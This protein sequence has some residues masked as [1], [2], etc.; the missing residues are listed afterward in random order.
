MKSVAFGAAAVII[1]IAT[2]FLG[3]SMFFSDLGPSESMVFRFSTLVLLYAVGGG[4]IGAL[5]PRAWYVAILAAWG[6]VLLTLP[7]LLGPRVGTPSSPADQMQ[8]GLL[9]VV[10]VPLAAL[11]FAFLGTRV[12]RR[13]EAR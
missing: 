11:A 4:A 9:G 13:F 7:M 2:G 8:Q 1:A 5:V 3:L 12:R 10:V 6:P